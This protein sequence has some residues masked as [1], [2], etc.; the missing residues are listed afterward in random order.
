MNQQEKPAGAVGGLLRVRC[1][2][3]YDGTDFHGW[4]AQPGRRTVQGELEAAL[5]TVLRVPDDALP[6]A[7]CAGRTDA[8]VH[9][10]DQHVHVDL[11]AGV[12]QQQVPSQ[13]LR[14]LNG[15][16]PA[17][18]RVFDLRAAEPGFDARFSVRSRTYRYRVS[19]GRP[20]DPLLR[21]FVVEH[22]AE[23]DPAAM[24]RAAQSLLGEHDFAAFCRRRPGASSTRTLRTLVWEDDAAAQGVLALVITADAFCH[25]MVRSLVGALLP[26]GD[27]RRPVEWPMQVLA[28]GCRRPDVMVA[29]A[30]G[31]VLEAVDYPEDLGG[32]AQRSRRIRGPIAG[33]DRPASRQR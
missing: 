29:P 2:L 14:R 7:V 22:P 23:L 24:N 27:G 10:R 6:R 20:V 15:L 9:A 31:L 12:W 19:A 30:H 26:V 33:A 16:L 11:P 4:A 17:D 21:R 1:R 3:A 8:G 32:Q 28:G 5:A 13:L 18:V 25:S